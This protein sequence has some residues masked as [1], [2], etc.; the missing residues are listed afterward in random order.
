MTKPKDP[1]KLEAYNARERLRKAETPAQR[2]KCIAQLNELAGKPDLPDG[3]RLKGSS[4]LTDSA[5]KLRERWDKTERDSTPEGELPATPPDFAITKQ[6]RFTDAQGK[7]RGMWT[8]YQQ[9]RVEQDAAMRKAFEEFAGNYSL[10]APEIKWRGLANDDRR[11]LI[12]IGDP[13]V[14]MLAHVREA[15]NTFD[16]RIAERELLGATDLL[17][18]QAPAASSCSIVNLGDWFHAQDDSQLTPRGHNKQDVDGRLWKIIEISLSMVERMCEQALAKYAEVRFTFIP[19]NHDPHLA[20]VFSLMLRRIFRDNPRITIP[21]TLDPFVIEVF[22]DCLMLYNH[23]D[24]VKLADLVGILASHFPK[25]WG[26]ARHR[27]IHGGHV[28]HSEVKEMLGAVGES[29]NTLAGSDS[30]HRAEGYGARRL[31][32]A[33]C[34]HKKHGELCRNTASLDLVREHLDGAL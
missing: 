5:G 22:G 13:H 28:H 30:W 29:H 11:I 17:I 8:A 12:P 23:T 16:L 2:D 26:A 14:G 3:H 4:V 15:G 10:R 21:D 6:S 9:D 7:V 31:L 19:G 1:S 33:I 32:K 18:S 24:K 34:L 25:E 27:F 20:M